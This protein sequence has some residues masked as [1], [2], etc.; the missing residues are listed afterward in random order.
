MIAVP[1]NKPSLGPEEA[2]AAARVVDSGWVAQGAEVEHFEAE[3]AAHVG[4][5]PENVLVTASGSAALFL[6]LTSAG[7]PVSMVHVP[8]Y[9]CSAPADVSHLVG[10]PVKFVDSMSTSPCADWAD[11]PIDD[12]QAV[13]V[14]VDLFGLPAPVLPRGGARVISDAAQSFGATAAGVPTCLWG[15]VGIASFSPTKIMT[16][17]GYGGALFSRQADWIE[18]AR[19]FRDWDARTDGRRRFH[20]P[21]GD[22][23]A[24]I[25]RVQLRRLPEMIEARA[26]IISNYVAAGIP[27]WTA[28]DGESSSGY[29]AIVEESDPSARIR[30]MRYHGVTSIIPYLDEEMNGRGIDQSPA[31]RGWATRLISLPV[32][33]DMTPEQCDLVTAAWSSSS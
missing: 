32:F 15:D 6:A 9:G 31:A 19:D 8:T 7:H 11:Q 18:A 28:N 24:A 30:K 12:S 10:L 23:A 13:R 17:G 33:P 26:A 22:V 1:H 2:A 5:P 16:V 20:L 25:G 14:S 21:L 3:L 29:R 4:V 27:V